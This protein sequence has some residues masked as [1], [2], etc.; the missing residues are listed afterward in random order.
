MTED[1][2]DFLRKYMI[3]ASFAFATSKSCAFVIPVD[4]VSFQRGPL[5]DVRAIGGEDGDKQEGRRGQEGKDNREKCEEMRIYKSK[6]PALVYQP[7][8]T[9][10]GSHLPFLCI[11]G[12]CSSSQWDCRTT[13]CLQLQNNHPKDD[14]QAHVRAL[15]A[16]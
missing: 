6:N 12:L 10:S 15:A 13:V 8:V 3:Q 7:T 1:S 11:H 16:A 5:T 14:E 4:G 9:E 2:L